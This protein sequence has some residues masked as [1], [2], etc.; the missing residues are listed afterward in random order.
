MYKR[1]NYYYARN[2]YKI[3]FVSDGETVSE[4]AYTY[5][6]RIQ[7]PTVYKPGY[8]FAGWEPAVMQTVPAA[9]TTYTAVWKEADDVTY[10]TRYYIEDEN[11]DYVLERIKTGKGT[12]GQAVTAE[13]QDYGSRY[14]AAGDNPSG[15]ITADGSLVLKAYYER[16]AYDITYETS[17]GKLDSYKQA[18]KWGTKVIT[19]VPVRAGYAFMGWYT[20][21]E[22]THA[23]D[24]S[25]PSE[26]ITLY[27]KW[28]Q[29]QVNYTVEHF[30]EKTDGS[31][32]DLYER[33][34]Y[35]ADAD[36]YVTPEVL[37]MTGFS[38]PD[39]LTVQVKKD[40]STVVKYYYKRNI[41][42]LTL[43]LNN[44]DKDMV[45]EYRYGTKISV[46]QPVRKGYIFAGWDKDCL[47]Y[48]SPSPRD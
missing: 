10:S 9:D 37:N 22:C 17:G 32:Y 3:K 5:G 7:T 39:K 38:S 46:G 28:E 2:K 35:T 4:G 13:A 6:T 30:T 27:A 20:D 11:G 21:K 41:H 34:V 14:V 43:K 45:Y 26:N 18:A 48:T 40:G 36:S 44:G 31:G 16:S 15:K 29:S 23:F 47:L 24:G 25:M 42:K 19:Q 12:T 33:K 8:V 1:Q